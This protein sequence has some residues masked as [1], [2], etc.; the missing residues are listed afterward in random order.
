MQACIASNFGDRSDGWQ[1]FAAEAERR[2]AP[3][4][5]G[6]G[7]LGRCVA[8][9]SEYGVFRQHPVSVVGN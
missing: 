5:V 1:R 2:Q 3:E 4:I 8:L 9:E 7:E 6:A